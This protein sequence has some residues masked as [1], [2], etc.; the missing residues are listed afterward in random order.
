MTG[1]I[2]VVSLTT[3]NAHSSFYGSWRIN[4]TRDTCGYPWAQSVFKIEALI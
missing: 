2:L 4:C 3:E 1:R